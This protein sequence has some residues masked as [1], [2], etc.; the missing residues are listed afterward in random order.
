MRSARTV[1]TRA[2]E[3]ELAGLKVIGPGRPKN[4]SSLQKPWATNRVDQAE[5]EIKVPTCA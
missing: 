2:I 3:T 4:W 5:G 1:V